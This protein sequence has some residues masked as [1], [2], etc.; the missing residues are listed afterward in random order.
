MTAASLRI[1]RR[2]LGFRGRR[3]PHEPLPTR[4]SAHAGPAPA[5]R[6]AYPTTRCTTP[7]PPASRPRSSARCARRDPPTATSRVRARA[8]RSMSGRTASAKASARRADRRPRDRRRTARAA[9]RAACERRP[10]SRGSDDDRRE[11]STRPR[12]PSRAARARRARE[13]RAAR[14]G[15]CGRRG[16]GGRRVKT[17]ARSEERG[18]DA[19]HVWLAAERRRKIR[20]VREV[21]E[22][23]QRAPLSLHPRGH[24]ATQLGPRQAAMVA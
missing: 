18:E 2:E 1:A 17:G 4:R 13:G 19:L 16:P 22:L 23:R 5:G 10:W 7:L 9:L 20:R 14:S 21:L 11:T 24:E 3:P 15:R 8:P 6:R 12:A